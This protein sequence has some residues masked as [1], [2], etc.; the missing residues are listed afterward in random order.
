VYEFARTHGHVDMSE[1]DLNHL[2]H[3][4]P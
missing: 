4:F 1:N 2:P 3:P